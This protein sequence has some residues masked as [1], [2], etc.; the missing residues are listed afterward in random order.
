MEAGG[1]EPPSESRATQA[2]TSIVEVYSYGRRS[3]TGSDPT[4]PD[5]F[6]TAH[7]K[8]EAADL[9]G[10]FLRLADPYRRGTGRRRP[11]ISGVVLHC[12]LGSESIL[13]LCIG[14]CCFCPFLRG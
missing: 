11:G 2:S 5:W 13:R 1:V 4:S 3:S 6:Q 14:S 10:F 9:V 12:L 7:R 8:A